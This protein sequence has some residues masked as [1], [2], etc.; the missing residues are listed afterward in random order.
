MAQFQE[1]ERL[2]YVTGQVLSVDEFQQEQ[3]YFRAHA[4]RH[5]RFLHGWG[6]V[7]GLEVAIDGTQIVVAPGLA[8]DCAGNEVVVAS[9][10]TIP[11]PPPKARL[12]VTI[13]YVELMVKQ[14]P[15]IEGG[16]AFSR[17]RESSRVE[18][19]TIDPG[20]NH[21]GRGPGTPGCGEAH[22]LALAIL[23]AKGSGWR[24]NPA[25]PRRR[26]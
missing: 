3:D 17:I 6:I 19:L 13:S 5:N 16:L 4:Q 9:P 11:L 20:T 12:F 10:Q 7:A 21:R 2:H 15:S 14:M 22:A 23:T 1:L 26:Y 24:L 18:L 25:R 8:I